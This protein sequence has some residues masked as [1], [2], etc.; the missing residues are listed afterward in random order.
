M[1][2]ILDA[3]RKADAERER[4]HV[5]DLKAQQ[6]PPAVVD[7]EVAASGLPRWLGAA[8]A[9]GLLAAGAAWWFWPTEAPPAAALRPP[10]VMLQPPPA[11][12]PPPAAAPSA[13]VRQ[14]ARAAEGAL[15]SARPKAVP[16]APPRPAPRAAPIAPAPTRAPAVAETRDAPPS[17]DD[18]APPTVPSPAVQDPPPRP[19]AAGPAPTAPVAAV[20]RPGDPR[21]AR[22]PALA[23]LP[24]DLRRQVPAMAVGGSIYSPQPAARMVIVN[25]QVFQEGAVLGPE[26]LLE[27]IRPKSAVFTIRGQRFEV[28]L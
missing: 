17:A 21:P 26:L 3:L 18:G 5:P 24:E 15:A 23:E 14:S 9:G 16:A 25:G 11:V 6:L 8:V 20:S 13:P 19:S 4:G 7:D 1:S 28:P 2:Y 10:V 27:Q 22:I 12:A